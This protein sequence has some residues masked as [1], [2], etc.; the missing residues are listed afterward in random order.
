MQSMHF[1]PIRQSVNILIVWSRQLYDVVITVRFGRYLPF[2]FVNFSS[3]FLNT[4]KYYFIYLNFV[5]YND[6]LFND[7]GEASF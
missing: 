2:L 3:V 1:R 7:H 4:Q 5:H 6:V